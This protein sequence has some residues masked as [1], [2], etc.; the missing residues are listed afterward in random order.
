MSEA[1]KD[2]LRIFLKALRRNQDVDHRGSLRQFLGDKSVR[3]KE[4]GCKGNVSRKRLLRD[5]KYC[6][7]C[8]FQCLVCKKTVH[9]NERAIGLYKGCCLKCTQCEICGQTMWGYVCE[10]CTFPR[11]G[12]VL[13]RKL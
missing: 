9:G 1:F 11:R 4:P 10:P 12:G 2:A 7:K 5:I 8:D 6:K 13:I 3:C